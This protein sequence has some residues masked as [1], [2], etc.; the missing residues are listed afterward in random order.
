[1]IIFYN[2]IIVPII[3]CSLIFGISIFLVKMTTLDS[4]EDDYMCDL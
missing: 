1:M 4:N 2:E 3:Q